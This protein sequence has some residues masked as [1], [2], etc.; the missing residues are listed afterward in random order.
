MRKSVYAILGLTLLTQNNLFASDDWILEGNV[1]AA[2]ISDDS[3]ADGADGDEIH[4]LA[5]GGWVTLKTPAVKGFRAVGT[6]YTSQP[7]FGQNTDQWLTE[8]DGSSYSYIGEAYVTGPIFGNTAVVLGKKVIDTPFADSDDI[9]MAPNSFEVYLVQN[10]DIENVTLLAG[11][12]LKWAGHDAPTRGEFTDMTSGNGVSVAAAIYGNEDLGLSG[13]AWFYHLD[14]KNNVSDGANNPDLN[15]YYVDG[16]Y[17]YQGTVEVTL[18]A[19]YARFE[20]DRR[21]ANNKEDDIDGTVGGVQIEM[22]YGNGS[23]GAAFNQ[24]DGDFAPINGF[25]GGPF[26]VNSDILGLPDAGQDGSAYKF[27]AGYD[28]NDQFS[29]SAGY[30]TLD[31]DKGDTFSELDLGASYAYSSDLTFDFYFE[32]W[33]DADDVDWIEY[34][35]FMNYSF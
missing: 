6:V 24:A 7:L 21:I 5:V 3:D 8:T 12:V 29:V 25:G 35:V 1:R 23:I 33:T 2:Y 26:Y 19:Q 14:N 13:Q 11:R 15:I 20:T 17:T 31:P 30:L 18:S 28:I 22:G 27:F 32:S 16:S 10:N 9:G 34:S 4:D